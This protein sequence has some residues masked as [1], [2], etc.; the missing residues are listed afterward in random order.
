MEK[1]NDR[2]GIGDIIIRETIMKLEIERLRAL[3]KAYE[4]AAKRDEI[5]EMIM[6]PKIEV[7]KRCLDNLIK[8]FDQNQRNEEIL[9]ASTDP[10]RRE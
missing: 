3:K 9:P 2:K 5:S 4:E 6:K 8:L 10:K 7:T 1:D